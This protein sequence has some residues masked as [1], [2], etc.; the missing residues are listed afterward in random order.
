MAESK[1]LTTA[2]WAA[3][4]T[5]WISKNSTPGKRLPSLPKD[6]KAG[7]MKARASEKKKGITSHARI[8]TPNGPAFIGVRDLKDK[9]PFK[10]YYDK[11]ETVKGLNRRAGEAEKVITW[12][13]RLEYMNRNLID[14]PE[15]YSTRESYAKQLEADD[16]A[17]R[18]AKKAENARNGKGDIYEHLLPLAA[19]EEYGGFEHDLNT[20]SAP[21]K[22][23][24]IKSAKIASS[25]TAREQGV[26]TSRSSAMY[27]E[28]RGQ[29]SPTRKTFD[30]FYEDITTNK[31]KNVQA[32][33]K[34]SDRLKVQRQQQVDAARLREAKKLGGRYQLQPPTPKGAGNK[35]TKML[36]VLGKTAYKGS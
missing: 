20:V 35:F 15:G 11:T 30:A 6:L 22:E 18:A 12:K 7:Y 27:K 3:L 9:D 2:Y 36:R 29:A 32:I 16:A 21:A 1:K 14:P 13:E 28:M 8:K 23:N 17:K 10:L 26:P 34:K 33:R 19:P 4:I 5:K 24:A 31:R 25:Q